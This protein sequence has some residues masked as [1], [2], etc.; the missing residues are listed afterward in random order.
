MIVLR[1]TE[2]AIKIN[3]TKRKSERD[4]RAHKRLSHIASKISN[5]IVGGQKSTNLLHCPMQQ[6]T[7]THF[8]A[9]N[10][11]TIFMR[12]KQKQ[13][14]R[15]RRKI[16]SQTSLFDS[17]IYWSIAEPS[18]RAH[19]HCIRRQTNERNS[20]SFIF[21]FAVFFFLIWGTAAKKTREKRRASRTRSNRRMS[22]ACKPIDRL[23]NL[24][25]YSFRSFRRLHILV[26]S[27]FLL[28]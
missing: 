21:T 5:K 14:R 10:T 12:R 11:I 9:M 13:R 4:W 3:W 15:R 2:N 1:R 17:I 8:Y 20:I 22:N 6:I 23:S 19:T 24:L 28:F 16:N 27:L 18:A 7:R 26:L 25:T